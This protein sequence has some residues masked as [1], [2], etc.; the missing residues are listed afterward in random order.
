MSRLFHNFLG[1]WM[2]LSGFITST[3]LA[4]IETIGPNGINSAG[5]GL[6][7]SGI[8][9]GQVENTRP[10]LPTFDSAANTHSSVEPTAVFVKA[11][12]PRSEEHTSEL[13]SH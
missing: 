8:G 7:G 11:D 9:I 5:L 13:Q 1:T 12:D 2:I 6:T 3:A 4:S 10:G